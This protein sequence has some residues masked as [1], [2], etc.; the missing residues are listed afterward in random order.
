MSNFKK[1]FLVRKE[2]NSD[3]IS[4]LTNYV[5]WLPKNS[6]YDFVANNTEETRAEILRNRLV[7]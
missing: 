5:W 6:F 3:N 4:T 2:E 1:I 7:L